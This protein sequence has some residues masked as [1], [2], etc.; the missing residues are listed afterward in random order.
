MLRAF[1][2][3]IDGTLVDSVDFHAEAWQR[4]LAHFGHAVSFHAVRSQIGKGGDQLMPVFLSEEEVDYIGEELERYR[5]E[6]FKRDYLPRVRAF[7]GTRALFERIRQ[8][9]KQIVLASS[10]KAGEVLIYKRIAQ[11]EDLVDGETSADDVEVSKP[12]ADIFRA[13]LGK[14]HGVRADAALVV[15]DSPYD[16]EAAGKLG[17]ATVG[18]L[19]GG[20]PEDDLRD[21]GCFAIYRDPED[22]LANYEAV[23]DAFRGQVLQHA[24]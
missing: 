18:L 6:L 9:G 4:A 11:V 23:K 8:D 22:L 19:C 13:A 17:L 10:S 3:D 21:A 7:P 1:I 16:P 12:A 20:F 5:S 2:F 24:R 15:G 14:L